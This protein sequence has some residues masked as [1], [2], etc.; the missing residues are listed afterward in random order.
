MKKREKSIW[1]CCWQVPLA[2]YH[3]RQ[4]GIWET[5]DYNSELFLLIDEKDEAF[6][7][8]LLFNIGWGWVLW[9]L[10]TTS[11]RT[12][13]L[14]SMDLKRGLCQGVENTGTKMQLVTYWNDECQ[15]DMGEASKLCNKT[16]NETEELKIS[17]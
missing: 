10:V 3:H 15:E 7:L 2:D 1:E 13:F 8:Q 5:L 12:S 9:I 6:I 16:L 17:V 11:S 14:P 4:L